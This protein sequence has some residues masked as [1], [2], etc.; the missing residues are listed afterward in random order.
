MSQYTPQGPDSSAIWRWFL[1]GY[2]VAI[3]VATHVPSNVVALPG[4]FTDK[5]VHALMFAVLSWLLAMAWERST[6]KLNARHL[7]NA[8]VL[9]V[10]YAAADELTQPWFGRTASFGDWLADGVGVTAG[11]LVF[12]AW[13]RR[14]Q[15]K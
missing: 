3:C 15:P 14:I 11:L 10:L 1:V 8:W 9:L 2:W 7:R 5:P 13:Q 6:G 4:R 12:C